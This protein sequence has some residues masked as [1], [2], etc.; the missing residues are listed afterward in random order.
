[1]PLPVVDPEHSRSVVGRELSDNGDGQ[2]RLSEMDDDL[3]D[4]A[5][6]RGDRGDALDPA[7]SGAE[8][9]CAVPEELRESAVA[10][11]RPGAG[12]VHDNL[13][14]PG[15]LDRAHSTDE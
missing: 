9:L 12:V 8:P 10:G 5:A 15:I 6:R 4:D 1:M 14:R 11:D 2:R 7:A 3:A 13:D